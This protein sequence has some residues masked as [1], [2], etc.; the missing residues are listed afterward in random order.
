MSFSA[1]PRA[2]AQKKTT[3]LL[4]SIA[5]GFAL[6][7]TFCLSAAEKAEAGIA[8]PPRTQQIR[9]SENT[10]IVQVLGRSMMDIA[11]GDVS[12]R[13][14][15][16]AKLIKFISLGQSISVRSSSKPDVAYGTR[17]VEIL[18]ALG[19]NDTTRGVRL[20]PTQAMSDR[21]DVLRTA[22]IPIPLQETGT[23][24]PKSAV[25]FASGRH[26]VIKVDT[27]K[28]EGERESAIP[29]QILAETLDS[30]SIRPLPGASIRDGDTILA[31]R[32]IYSLPL[33]LE[34]KKN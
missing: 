27:T 29:I 19:S 13:I 26:Y 18:P 7:L 6:G 3:I 20:K 5:I 10:R 33:L 12:I 9:F 34:E 25:A 24:V 30:L 14:D 11:T 22:D 15:V 32:A 1:S 17:V 4:S 28:K 31:E 2:S 23:R 16:P 21:L 8:D